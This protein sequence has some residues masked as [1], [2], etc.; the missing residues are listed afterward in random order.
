MSLCAVP[1][2]LKQSQASSGGVSHRLQA[3]EAAMYRLES[4]TAL[5]RRLK[6]RYT[7]IGG[8]NLPN[9]AVYISRCTPRAARDR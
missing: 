9:T 5:Q 1:G 4:L 2:S 3:S 8:L 6:S 7:D